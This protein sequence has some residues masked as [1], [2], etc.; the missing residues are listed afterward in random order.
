MM[1]I[2]RNKCSG[3]DLNYC[4]ALIVEQMIP[5]INWMANTWTL[6]NLIYDHINNAE[7]SVRSFLLLDCCVQIH[8][9]E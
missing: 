7:S 8:E 6:F 2:D 9:S 4:I 3:D 1:A 5:S